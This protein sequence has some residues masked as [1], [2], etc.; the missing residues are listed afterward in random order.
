MSWDSCITIRYGIFNLVNLILIFTAIAYIIGINFPK[1]KKFEKIGE[2]LFKI[3][4]VGIVLFFV[5]PN[6]LFNA[7]L[8]DA[9]KCHFSCSPPLEDYP[10]CGPLEGPVC[11]VG[12][13]KYTAGITALIS[14]SVFPVLIVL[15]IIRFANKFILK[16]KKKLVRIITVIILLFAGL[17]GIMYFMTILGIPWLGGFDASCMSCPTPLECYPDCLARAQCDF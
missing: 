14:F 5:G 2:N 4:V 11:L 8:L 12:Y 17:A 9:A 6:I 16:D 3:S 13:I 7:G 10:E 1:K 15:A